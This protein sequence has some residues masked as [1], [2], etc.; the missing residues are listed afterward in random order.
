MLHKAETAENNESWTEE[1]MTFINIFVVNI[2]SMYLF[3][4]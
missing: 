4:N 2:K 3:Y 1:I